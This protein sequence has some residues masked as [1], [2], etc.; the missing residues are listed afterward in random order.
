M[1][2]TGCFRE[3]QEGKKAYATVVGSIE[4]FEDAKSDL[5]FYPDEIEP[6]ITVLCEKC[7]M[8]VHNFIAEQLQAKH[9]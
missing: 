3:L 5:G 4:N 2:C 6:W 1:K 8:M 9:L 7:G